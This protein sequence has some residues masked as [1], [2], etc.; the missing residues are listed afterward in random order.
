M[1]YVPPHDE[2]STWPR[3]IPVMGASIPAMI[4][5]YEK[6]RLTKDEV[7]RLRQC[8]FD[9]SDPP[10]MWNGFTV[11]MAIVGLC[12]FSFGVGCWV[13]QMQGLQIAKAMQ[14]LEKPE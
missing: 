4:D 7:R 9:T 12:C 3:S 10:S 2:R 6:G 13:G 1:G 8:D 14:T 11:F 5:L